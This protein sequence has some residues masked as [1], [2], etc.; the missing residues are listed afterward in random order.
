[1]KLHSLKNSFNRKDR[2]RVG[3]GDASGWGRCAGRGDKGSGQRA[4]YSRRLHF[5]GGQIPLLRRLPKRGF[6]NPNHAV[7]S[8]VN[9]GL[10][11][12]AFEGGASVD[13]ATLKSRGMLPKGNA[14]LKVLGDGEVSKALTVRARKFSAS[15]K[16]K[17]EAAGGTCEV[18]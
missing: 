4:G 10:L 17:I 9:V 16:Q 18:V 1:M 12:Q 7:Y 11:D 3:R 13:E 8:I 5:E 14:G 15:A 2:K 6:N